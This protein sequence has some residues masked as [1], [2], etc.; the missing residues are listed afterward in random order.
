MAI[1]VRNSSPSAA[2]SPE[3]TFF[4]TSSIWDKRRL[5]QSERSAQLF[6]NV[7]HDYRNQGKF[8]LHDF[9]IMPDHFHVLVTVGKEI[10]IERAV[11]FVKGGFAYRAGKELGFR[12]PVW[13]KGFSEIR[14]LDESA[15]LQFREYTRNNPV[16]A[17]LVEAPAQYRYSSAFAGVELDPMPQ[18]LKPRFSSVGVGASKDAP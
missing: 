1:P 5:L 16:R 13:Q 7:L 10:S 15:F 2:T 12:A 11:Q 18:R 3:R 4:V 9:V 6:L 14:V 8:R 17:R